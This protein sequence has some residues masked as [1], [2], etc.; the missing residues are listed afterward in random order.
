MMNIKYL[1]RVLLATI[2]L[3]LTA[4]QYEPVDPAVPTKPIIQPK[5]NIS[6]KY[7]MIA[8]N[9]SVPTD[10][11]NDGQSSTNQMKETTCYSNNNI[12]LNDDNTFAATLNSIGI[13]FD[14]SNYSLDCK[15]NSNI[16]GTWQLD[17]S[18]VTLTYSANNNSA[19]MQLTL[20]G[21]NISQKINGPIV[22]Q[23]NGIPATVQGTIEMMYTKQ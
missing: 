19:S 11:N 17:G 6:G 13:V 7:D 10:L 20:S 21:N 8:Y 22:T 12:I 4:C 23:T 14:G 5:P 1:T 15:Y 9:T 18:I 16:S 3:I 2:F